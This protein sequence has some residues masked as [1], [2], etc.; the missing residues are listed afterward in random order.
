MRDGSQKENMSKSSQKSTVPDDM[1]AARPARVRKAAGVQVAKA[2]RRERGR[3]RVAALLGA[4]QA[5]FAEKGFDAA[6]MTEIAQ[7][8]KAPIGSLY[9]FFANKDLLAGAL[10]ERYGVSLWQAMDRIAVMAPRLTVEALS[11]QLM[12]ALVSLKAERTVA[13]ALMEVAHGGPESALAMKAEL[14][15]RVAAILALNCPGVPVEALRPLAIAYLTLMK[16]AATL[17]AEADLAE[18]AGALDEMR[19]GARAFLVARLAAL[20]RS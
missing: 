10:L 17:E 1:P 6:T 18:R 9:Q 3:L 7:R 5:I 4:A 16:S 12:G 2:P 19:A 11:D 13:L 8:A 15:G 14:R 20:S